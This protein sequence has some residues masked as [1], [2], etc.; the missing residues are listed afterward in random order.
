MKKIILTLTLPLLLAAQACHSGKSPEKEVQSLLQQH[1]TQWQADGGSVLVIDTAGQVVISENWE[2]DGAG[3]YRKT[4]NHTFSTPAQMGSL[5]MP[6]ALIPALED[7]LVCWNDTVELADN[8]FRYD[9]VQVTDAPTVALFPGRRSLQDVVVASSGAGISKVMT[10]LYSKQPMMLTQK[11]KLIRINGVPS[12]DDTPTFLGVGQGY[13]VTM[14]PVEM[15]SFYYT[16]SK[17]D[18]TLCSAATM[19]G[20][21]EILSR[22]V[23]ER[24][25]PGTVSAA[26]K[27]GTVVSGEAVQSLFCGYFPADAPRY[28][29]LVRVDNPQTPDPETAAGN[30]FRQVA[31]LLAAE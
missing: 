2:A 19:N 25:E 1:L 28:T 11:L 24:L 7:S 5:L 27:T 3:A 13:G 12:P 31:A 29:C 14:T 30:L 15:L 26:G 4:G 21:R 10:D 20:I 6:F 16:V 18:T 8:T 23:T 22:T 17:N 9:G